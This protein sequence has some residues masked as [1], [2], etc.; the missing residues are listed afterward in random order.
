M[1]KCEKVITKSAKD[2][3][4]G[5]ICG[6]YTKKSFDGVFLCS[7][8]SK[9]VLSKDKPITTQNNE[10]VN[11][12]ITPVTPIEPIQENGSETSKME[13]KPVANNIPIIND[14]KTIKEGNTL[15]EVLDNE[16]KKKRIN[17]KHPNSNTNQNV[18]NSILRRLD[19]L[20]KLVFKP[21]EIPEMEIFN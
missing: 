18:I 12:T 11:Q 1:G 21:P 17:N 10:V 5:K 9:K 4:V 3:R 6:I 7:A 8:H 2:N 13:I 15:S 19:T 16:F 20:E 14:K